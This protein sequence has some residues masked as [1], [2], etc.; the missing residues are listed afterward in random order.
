MPLLGLWRHRIKG[1]MGLRI[2][3]LPLRAATAGA[4]DP[5]QDVLRANRTLQ[6]LP[7]VTGSDDR[8]LGRA[9]EIRDALLNPPE[10]PRSVDQFLDEAERLA[11]AM[12][13]VKRKS[14]VDP[15]RPPDTS[16]P[17]TKLPTPLAASGQRTAIY[18]PI[19]R[20]APVAT[21]L[22]LRTGE[23]TFTNHVRPGAPAFNVYV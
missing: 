6:N 1:Y 21:H 4:Y 17:E 23:S 7:E 15:V 10:N 2:G 9:P 22:D 20:R 11:E 13:A 19:A 8:Y 5:Y 12:R 16:L 3:A 18:G 14:A